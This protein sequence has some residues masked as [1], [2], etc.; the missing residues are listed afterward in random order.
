VYLPLVQAPPPD[1][2][3]WHVCGGALH[4]CPPEHW[5]VHIA[6]HTHTRTPSQ[7]S[8]FSFEQHQSCECK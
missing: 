8:W 4:T 2:R 3:H 1:R 7:F 6:M 5:G